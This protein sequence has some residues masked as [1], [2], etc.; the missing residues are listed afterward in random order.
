MF[1][2]VELIGRRPSTSH[3]STKSERSSDK[4]TLK[5]LWSHKGG[6]R[7]ALGSLAEETRRVRSTR[8]NRIT[9]TINRS[10][11]AATVTRCTVCRLSI[12]LMRGFLRRFA[13]MEK[14][15]SRQELQVHRGSQLITKTTS[16]RISMTM[17]LRIRIR[18]ITIASSKKPR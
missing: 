17:R 15:L 6:K 3:A 1:C 14:S 10:I 8:M 4:H 7:G 11:Y 9:P 5:S 18:S 16:S 13:Q 2:L 12:G